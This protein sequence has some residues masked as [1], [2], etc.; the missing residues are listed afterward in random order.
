M[1]EYSDDHNARDS[2]LRTSDVTS[3]DDLGTPDTNSNTTSAEEAME[4]GTH[5]GGTQLTF[6][7]SF[8]EASI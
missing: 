1:K 6:Q 2:T 3:H 8:T 7:S 4:R 5:R